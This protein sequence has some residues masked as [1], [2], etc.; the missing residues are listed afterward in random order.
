MLAAAA[1]AEQ[2]G[3]E[4]SAATTKAQIKI[5]EKNGM[6]TVNAPDQVISKMKEIGTAMMADW[7]KQASPEAVDVLDRYLALV[8]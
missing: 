6:A 3:W 8:Q 1:R 2:R 4:M 5:L 7:K